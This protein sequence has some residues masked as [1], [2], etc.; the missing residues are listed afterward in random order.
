M[1]APVRFK[2]TAKN[3]HPP[4]AREI[5]SRHRVDR[6]SL[7]PPWRAMPE[8]ENAIHR[9]A[10]TPVEP[11]EV[12]RNNAQLSFH[13]AAQ[14]GIVVRHVA[15]RMRD[16]RKRGKDI[17]SLRT[18]QDAIGS[19]LPIDPP[20]A[21]SDGVI[22][23]ARECLESV[24]DSS[25]GAGRPCNTRDYTRNSDCGRVVRPLRPHERVAPVSSRRGRLN[26]ANKGLPG[27]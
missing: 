21:V 26:R 20:S 7:L 17:P 19:G 23:L 4:S 8:R 27:G 25:S 22:V 6:R 24:E 5:T 13:G 3:D 10:E 18:G 11:I 15:D 12:A 14:R 9:T 1:V 16:R 2:T